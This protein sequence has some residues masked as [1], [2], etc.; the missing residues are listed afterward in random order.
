MTVQKLKAYFGVFLGKRVGFKGITDTKL[1]LVDFLLGK[2]STPES[3]CNGFRVIR[4]KMPKPTNTSC[5]HT[6]T[7]NGDDNDNDNDNDMNRGQLN[8]ELATT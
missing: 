3:V 7:S 4:R 6:L 5:I 1:I 2:H 8:V